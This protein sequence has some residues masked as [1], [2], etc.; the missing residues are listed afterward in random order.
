M[1]KVALTGGI[2]SGKSTVS[3]I[4]AQLGVPIIDA[5]IIAREVV[6]PGSES[7]KKL[8]VLFGQEI[9]LSDGS[10]NRPAL[11]KIIFHNK[12]ARKSAEDILHPAIRLRSE[13]LMKV[14]ARRKKPYCIHVIPLLYE[15]G[16]AKNYD[17][18][19]L[20]DVSLDTQIERIMQRDG[21]VKKEAL[22]IIQT[23]ATRE[24]RQII[25][26]EIIDNTGNIHGLQSIVEILHKK[27]QLLSKSL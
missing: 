15:T 13:Q 16:Q 12:A 8:I 24:Q 20:V 27:F 21:V 7:L 25:A 5:D 19:V 23:Q 1:L 3:D 4:F 2:A 6:E 26:T 10:L 14:Y 18:V 17:Q 9:M 22:T 11:R